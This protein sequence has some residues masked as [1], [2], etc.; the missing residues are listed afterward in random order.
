[1]V[2]N[3]LLIILSVVFLQL[4]GFSQEMKEH[5]VPKIVRDG[6]KKKYPHVYIY[7]WE[8]K[9]KRNVYQVEFIIKGNEYPIY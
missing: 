5:E 4:N 6:V 9:K 1:M 3:T 7:E 8:W 2:K